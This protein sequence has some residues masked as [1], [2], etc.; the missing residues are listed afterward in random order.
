LPFL[1]SVCSSTCVRY[2]S[3]LVHRKRKCLTVSLAW[4][5]SHWSD[6][7]API[8]WRYP[9]SRAIPVRSYANILA[10]LRL[11]VSYRVR[12]CLPGSAVSIS[13]EYLPTPSGSALFPRYFAISMFI[14]VDLARCRCSCGECPCSVACRAAPL[15]VLPSVNSACV[16]THTT[17]IRFPPFLRFRTA[18]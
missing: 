8:R 15:A 5:H 10:S 3:H 14:V 2:T 7:A 18:S 6:S 17:Q 13:F 4:P 1:G 12:V 11:R 16:G 9:L